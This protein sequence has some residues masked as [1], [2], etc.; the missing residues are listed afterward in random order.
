[1]GYTPPP[2]GLKIDRYEV[3]VPAGGT[4]TLPKGLVWVFSTSGSERIYIEV[5]KNGAWDRDTIT[6]TRAYAWES[7][8]NAY[9]SMTPPIISDGT[10]VRLYNSNTADEIVVLFVMS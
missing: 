4:Y 2:S 3:T 5:F 8:A 1:M 10:N 6:L 7:I 9:L